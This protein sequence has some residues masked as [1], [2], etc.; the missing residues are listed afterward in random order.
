MILSIYGY[1]REMFWA[2]VSH[3][4]DPVAGITTFDTPM[5]WCA[6]RQA[7]GIQV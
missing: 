1:L 5:I 4:H 7:P 6:M 2:A 3:R